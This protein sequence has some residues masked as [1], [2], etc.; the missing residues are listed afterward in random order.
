MMPAEGRRIKKRGPERGDPAL[1]GVLAVDKAAGPSSN[2]VLQ[3][4]RRALGGVKGGHA[5]TLDPDAEGVLLV[6]LGEGTKI[7]PFLVSLDK[8]YEGEMCFGAETDSYDRSGKIVA[9]APVEH[10]TEGIVTGKMTAF[11]GGIRQQPPMYSAVKVA[12]RRLYDL[13]RRGETVE[14]KARQVTIKEFSLLRWERPA[15]RFRVR[16]SSGT[17][18]R[19]LC[20]DLGRECGSAGHMTALKR[21]AVGSFRVERALPLE[22]LAGRAAG[23]LSELPLVSPARALSHLPMLPLTAE[24]STAVRQGKYPLPP[25]GDQEDLAVGQEVRL[26][27]EGGALVAVV[28][29]EGEGRPMPIRRVFSTG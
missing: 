21:T 3:K 16:C 4:V 29:F 24:E 26:I 23:G 17:Y 11:M 10:L 25:G 15:L 22:E 9:Q 13:A 20:H 28:G 14:R 8:E 1:H 6:C 12:G 7:V 5:G 2:A 18:I 27:D 19:S